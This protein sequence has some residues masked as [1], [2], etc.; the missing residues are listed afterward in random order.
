MTSKFTEYQQECLRHISSH[1]YGMRALVT[2]LGPKAL[3]RYCSS[4]CLEKEVVD[5]VESVDLWGA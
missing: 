2:A 1:L 3:E 5:L 4:G